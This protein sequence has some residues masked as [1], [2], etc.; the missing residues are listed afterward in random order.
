V[1]K[2]VQVAAPPSTPPQLFG[3]EEGHPHFPAE[4][5]WLA[6][7]ALPQVPQCAGSTVV[8]TQL[9]P[10]RVV[11]V[12][13][14]AT[15][16]PIEQARPAAQTLPHLPQLAGSLDSVEQVAPQRLCVEGQADASIS[17]DV[18]DV[19]ASMPPLVVLPLLLPQPAPT[20]AIAV[21]PPSRAVRAR[22]QERRRRRLP[23]ILFAF[24][25]PPPGAVDAAARHEDEPS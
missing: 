25:A 2:L 22:G 24:A 4:Q 23:I 20:T 7:H 18:S 15:H 16:A 9:W 11:P 17:F 8:S 6:A 10:H 13:Q 14:F 3:L 1:G 19:L 5:T 12:P 21:I